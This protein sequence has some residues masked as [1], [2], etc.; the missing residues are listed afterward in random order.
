M[1]FS[2]NS[3]PIWWLYHILYEQCSTV[4]CLGYIIFWHEKQYYDENHVPSLLCIF[5]WFLGWLPRTKIMSK[6][7]ARAFLPH[8]QNFYLKICR[9]WGPI[10]LCYYLYWVLIGNICWVILFFTHLNLWHCYKITNNPERFSVMP[11]EKY[12]NTQRKNT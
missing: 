4:M 6:V 5:Q 11:I 12:I 7:Y 10:F 2:Y 3:Y 8:N 9:Q 1:L